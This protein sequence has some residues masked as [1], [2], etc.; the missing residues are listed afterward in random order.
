[1][2][3]TLAWRAER[4]LDALGW[5]EA[6]AAL[7]AAGGGGRDHPA[8]CATVL[9]VR[10]RFGRPVLALRPAA[11]LG[12]GAASGGAFGPPALTYLAHAVGAALRRT[13]QA[14]GCTEAARAP[15]GADA[16]LAPEQLLLLVDCAGFSVSS[17]AGRKALRAPLKLFS[18]HWPERLGA[19]LI[20]NPSRLFALLWAVAGGLLDARTRAKVQVLGASSDPLRTRQALAAFFS[21]LGE[22]PASLGGDGDAPFDVAEYGARMRAEDAD[23]W[24]RAPPE[25]AGEAA[26]AAAEVFLDE[27]FDADGAESYAEDEEVEGYWDDDD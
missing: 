17:A 22:I 12:G 20:L 27:E 14:E 16:D 18:R 10:D 19:A 3:A 6:A 21:D 23:A 5:D 24:A 9:P 1:M 26:P 8:L 7:P 2:Q 15:R 4:R 11:L 25:V 13:E